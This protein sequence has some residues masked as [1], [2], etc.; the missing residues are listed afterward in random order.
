M[1][2]LHAVLLVLGA[3]FLAYLV[4]KTGLAELR[5]ELTSLGW[6]LIPLVLCEGFS[7]LIHT[8]AWRYCMSGPQ[9]SL[10]LLLLFRIRMATMMPV[11][12]SAA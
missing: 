4:R 11:S 8:V 6:G 3:A 1:K 10:P 12:A 2:K 5:Q 9:R 7:E